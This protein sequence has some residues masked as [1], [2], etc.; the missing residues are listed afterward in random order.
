M[1]FWKNTIRIYG[2]GRSEGPV[3]KEKRIH[4]GLLGAFSY[5]HDK[6]VKAG[7]KTLSFLQYLVVNHGRSISA[8][9]LLEQFWAEGSSQS[10][11]TAL[12]RMMFTIRGLLEEMFPDMDHLLITLPGCYTWNPDICLTLDTELFEAACLDGRRAAGEEKCSLLLQA[13]SLYRGDFLSGNDSEWALVFRQYYQTL[14]LDAC[15]AVLPI[16]Y[17]KEQWMQ[18]LDISS[19]AYRIDFAAEEF[20]LYQMHALIALGQPEQA[21]RQY[22]T[23]RDKLMQEYEIMPTKQAEQLCTLASSLRKSNL[24]EQDVF[25]LVYEDQEGGLAFFCTFDIFRQIVALERRHI[26]RSGQPSALVVVSLG[27]EAIPATDA[28]RLE[29]LLLEKLRTGDPV[30][31][32]AA[33]TYIL[34]LTGASTENAHLVMG[35]IDCDFHRVYRHSRADLTYRIAPL[36]PEE[37]S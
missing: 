6:S 9:E 12:R 31:R 13:V 26:R 30:A 32:L 17:Q 21:I 3:A 16:L 35:R 24:G 7:R 23:F 10:P 2:R 33:D 37:V 36:Q 27:K 1:N 11:G 8:E 22:E 19:Q 18:L 20:T 15:K 5:S 28:R 4:F 25:Q 34:M 29:R 14:Y